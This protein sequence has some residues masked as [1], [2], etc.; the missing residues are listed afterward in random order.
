MEFS[1]EGNNY[2]FSPPSVRVLCGDDTSSFDYE[3][4]VRTLHQS[5]DAARLVHDALGSRCIV[6][7]SILC[8]GNWPGPHTSLSLVL[9]EVIRALHLKLRL[10]DRLLLRRVAHNVGVL[11]SADVTRLVES[12]L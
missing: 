3:D 6:C 8:R 7:D 1:R 5:E 4:L 9:E 10:S 2:P 12:F 11:G